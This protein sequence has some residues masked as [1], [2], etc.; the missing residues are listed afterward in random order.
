MDSKFNKQP[1]GVYDQIKN[2][3]IPDREISLCHQNS[4][5]AKENQF[6]PIKEQLSFCL[7]CL[8]YFDDKRNILLNLNFLIFGK[9]GIFNV[10]IISPIFHS[11]YIHSELIWNVNLTFS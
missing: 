4:N 9:F 1:K 7:E 8:F 10:H 11:K 2:I 5:N 6:R 3:R